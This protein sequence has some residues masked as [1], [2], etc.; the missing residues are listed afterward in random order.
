MGEYLAKRIRERMLSKLLTFEI[1]WFD[2]DEN[3]SGVVCFRLAKTNVVRLLVGDCIA[4]ILQTLSAVLIAWTMGLVIAWKLAIV[5]IA[6]LPF[7]PSPEYSKCFNKPK[8]D[9]NVKVLDN[10]GMQVLVL[11]FPKVSCHLLG[12]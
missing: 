5:M 4:L 3:C 6:V 12:P 2:Q 10:H 7:R 8:K 1:G 11:E 9:S